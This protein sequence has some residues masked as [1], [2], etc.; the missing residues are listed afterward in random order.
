LMTTLSFQINN[1]S[2]VLDL[3]G[4]S[5]SEIR[6]NAAH[7]A[8]L[9]VNGS[10]QFLFGNGSLSDTTGTIRAG[11]YVSAGTTFTASGCANSTLVGG[12]TAGT[13][14]SVT[15]GTC[16]VTVTMGNSATAPHGWIC[17]AHDLTTVADAN[18]VTLGSSTT[19]TANL[20][21]GTVVANDVIA[22]KCTGY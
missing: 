9:T 6:F 21:E 15:A 18:N 10:E 19:T 20:V 5:G 22:F 17:D 13:Y 4:S 16:T 7:N 1:S 12:A 14:T 8:G 11:G 3:V 2:N